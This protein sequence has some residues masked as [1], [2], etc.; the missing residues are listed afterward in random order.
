MKKIELRKI[1][2]NKSLSEE[3][4]AY[5]ADVYVDGVL[6]CH[7]SNHG[8]GGCDEQHPAK[9]KTYDDVKALNDYC[10]ATFP[11]EAYDFGEGHKGESEVDLESLCGKLLEDSLITKDLQRLLKRTVAFFDPKDKSIRSYKGKIPDV[12]RPSLVA[13]TLKKT[14]HAI[15]LN[16]LPFADAMKLFKEA[17]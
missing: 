9:G 14:P 8:T 2:H 5:T 13:L 16:D 6:T 15:I 12:A 4:N 3:T 11:K 1:S 17:A 7:V 10:K